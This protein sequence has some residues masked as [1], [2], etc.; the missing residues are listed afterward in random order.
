[1]K[2]LLTTTLILK[3]ADTSKELIICTDAYLEGLG[4]VLILDNALIDYKSR[5]L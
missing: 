3:I 1:M 5:K 2:Q 4:G